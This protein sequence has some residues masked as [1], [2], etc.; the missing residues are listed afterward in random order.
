[1]AF[2][3]EPDASQGTIVF[4]WEFR[5]VL[6]RR[7][8][9][10]GT[11]QMLAVVAIPVADTD[12]INDSLLEVKTRSYWRKYNPK[13]QTSSPNWSWLP[14]RV[15]R[16]ARRESQPQILPVPSTAG[17]QSA[18]A[19]SVTGISWVNS[20]KGKATVIVNGRNFFSGTKVVMGG[21]V[22]KEED[23]SITLKSDQAL[24]FETTIDS[25]TTGD[26]V[27]S[28]RFGPAQRLRIPN[29][30]LPVASL[31]IQRATIR[32]LR[33]SK[34]VRIRIDIA[35]YDN[36]GNNPPLT[37]ADLLKLPDPILFVGNE[38]VA[39]PYDYYERSPTL[40]PDDP[41]RISVEAWI[42]SQSLSRSSSVSFRVPFCGFD[43][44]ASQP[45]S[46]ADPTVTRMG[47]DKD[48]TVF[49]IFY[50]QGF[51]SSTTTS[52]SLSVDLDKTYT[53]QVVVAGTAPSLVRTADTE[54]RF[55][56]ANA[57]LSQYQNM[58]VR[59]GSGEPFLLPIPP[60][61]K[62][63]PKPSIDRTAKTPEITK[64][65]HGP[66]EWTGTALDTIT[67]VNWLQPSTSGQ[68]VPIAQQFTTYAG[69]TRLLV[70]LSP[71]ST[72]AE[73]KIALECIT[74]SAEKLIL[75]AFVVG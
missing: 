1:V 53:D 16:S 35:A 18:L 47:Q 56:V 66:I 49:R 22:H 30:L 64:A 25:L 74:A 15:D 36:H 60:A 4:G 57:V 28:G 38:P 20:G 12:A 11:R 50:P 71:G 13:V 3:R 46:F 10:A 48:N 34:A 9:S 6:G 14:W 69:G 41:T 39:M 75:T 29:E 33:K 8:V 51:G 61:D 67:D 19:P 31:D 52:T 5:P 7:T 68:P 44:Q 27:L 37:I 45:L 70:Y 58:V 62:V 42:P 55:T 23:G 72:D 24:E 2:E 54:Y 21:E 43:Y 63:P 17:I 26:G 73:G 65:K 40:T 32:P 59:I